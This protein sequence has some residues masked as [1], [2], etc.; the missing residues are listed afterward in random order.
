MSESMIDQS[1]RVL[2]TDFSAGAATP[3]GGSAAA[4]A[5][6]IAAALVER[7]A[8]AANLDEIAVRAR[9]L[10][11]QLVD[12]AHQDVVALE[13][14][15]NVL[16]RMNGGQADRN[17]GSAAKAASRPPEVAREAAREIGSLAAMLGRNGI[18]RLRGE[19]H[20]AQLLAEASAVAADAV[21][22]L[23]TS[24]AEAR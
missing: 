19:A 11:A 22:A 15:V 5:A 20:C 8:V 14:L 24:L 10:R 23:N 6:A 18:P 12:A 16:G 1:F 3:G 9:V 2:L 4:L 21:I 17:L 13:A 7:C